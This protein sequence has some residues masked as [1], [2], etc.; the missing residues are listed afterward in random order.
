MQIYTDEIKSLVHGDDPDD[1]YL[2]P[3]QG[4]PF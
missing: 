4:L 1:F 3:E 2:E